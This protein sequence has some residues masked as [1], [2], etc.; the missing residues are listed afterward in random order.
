[1]KGLFI[2]KKRRNTMTV[3][4]KELYRN[5]EQYIDKEIEIVG[6]IRTIRSSKNFGF[7]EI[8]DGTFFSN[9][10]VVFGNELDNFK[11]IGK[12]PIGSALEITG[13]LVST[14]EAKQK[15]EIKA[16]CIAV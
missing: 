14:P 10:Q 5:T 8:N 2:L 1:M 9:V 7:I 6:W 15:F 16:S 4:I 11:E 12:F 3:E 13:I